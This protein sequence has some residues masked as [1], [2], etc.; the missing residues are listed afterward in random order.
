MHNIYGFGSCIMCNSS[1]D[2]ALSHEVPVCIITLF[3][4]D[5][6]VNSVLA[7]VMIG[8][9]VVVIVILITNKSLLVFIILLIFLI[10][11]MVSMRI[12]SCRKVHEGGGGVQ[13]I[14]CVN[15]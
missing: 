8:A 15:D 2:I 12:I 14:S 1:H 7:I 9:L 10:P 5:V 6:A 13:I 3:M 4:Q 11:L